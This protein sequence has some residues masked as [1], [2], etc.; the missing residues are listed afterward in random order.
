MSGARKLPDPAESP[1]LWAEH[2]VTGGGTWI[3]NDLSVVEAH[4]ARGWELK[5]AP[6]TANASLPTDNGRP[7]GEWIEL[8]HPETL[9]TQLA[10]NQPGV[11]ESL[12]ALGWVPTTEYEAES[13]EG[14]A[15]DPAPKKS[16][17]KGSAAADDKKE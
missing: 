3:P 11:V 12:R 5:E 1:F 8:T 10:P 17:G 6:V 15:P 2:S 14:D 7:A 9:G 4:E 16:S 13:V